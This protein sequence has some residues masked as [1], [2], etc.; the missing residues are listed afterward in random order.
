MLLFK[1]SQFKHL[2]ERQGVRSQTP[3][4]TWT[5]HLN[6]LRCGQVKIAAVVTSFLFQ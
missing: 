2:P 1:V 3:D 6:S 5:C 4:V